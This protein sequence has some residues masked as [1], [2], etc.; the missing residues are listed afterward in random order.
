MRFRGG[1]EVVLHSFSELTLNISRK[2]QVS[3]ALSPVLTEHD[4][5]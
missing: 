5:G 1:V 3:A 4:A 2:L